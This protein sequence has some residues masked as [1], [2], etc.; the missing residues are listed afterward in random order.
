MTNSTEKPCNICG[1]SDFFSSDLSWGTA[2]A[3][4]VKDDNKL[5]VFYRP[6]GATV[7]DGDIVI[8]ARRCDVFGNI[9]FFAEL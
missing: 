8:S 3:G 7:E 4:N 2:L 5:R 6:D 9:V 1:N